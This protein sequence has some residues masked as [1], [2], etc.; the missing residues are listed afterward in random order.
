MAI[1]TV[2]LSSIGQPHYGTSPNNVGAFTGVFAYSQISTTAGQITITIQNTTD[3]SVAG[4][5]V[6][7]GWCT[8]T[9]GSPTISSLKIS[10][11]NTGFDL[12]NTAPSAFDCLDA[13]TG[14]GT[15]TMGLAIPS[16][17]S[18]TTP[19]CT[20][21]CPGVNPRGARNGIRSFQ[22]G[23]IVIDVAGTSLGSLSAPNFVINTSGPTHPVWLPV[24]FKWLRNTDI[25]TNTVVGDDYVSSS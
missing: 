5:I 6:A 7:I 25:Q 10:F 12:I 21:N 8:P 20:W 4:S 17:E 15:A 3:P 24:H 18:K 16:T 23:T 2:G 9:A 13:T 1:T 11:N 14:Y 19:T 22:I